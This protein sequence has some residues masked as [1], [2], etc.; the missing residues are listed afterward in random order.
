MVWIHVA[1]QPVSTVGHQVSVCGMCFARLAYLTKEVPVRR[2]IRLKGAA[3]V[4]PGDPY[5][6]EDMR[7]DSF[8]CHN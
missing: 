6:L 2:T 5:S 3:H 7:R 8:L 4:S 1:V